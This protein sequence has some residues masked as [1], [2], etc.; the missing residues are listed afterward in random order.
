MRAYAQACVL[1][2]QRSVY[3]RPFNVAL[4]CE[5][6][7]VKEIYINAVHEKGLGTI[8]AEGI[9]CKGLCSAY[10]STLFNYIAELYIEYLALPMV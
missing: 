8:C 10:I 1:G 9:C 2:F 3:A 6:N 5:T 7:A 4:M